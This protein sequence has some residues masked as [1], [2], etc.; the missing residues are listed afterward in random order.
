[1]IP[2]NPCLFRVYT[3][4]GEPADQVVV[5]TIGKPRP[6]P[7]GWVCRNP[8]PRHPEGESDRRR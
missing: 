1:M 3:V 8:D 7:G 6:G 4:A 5:L 2:K